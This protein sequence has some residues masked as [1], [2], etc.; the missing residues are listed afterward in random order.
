MCADEWDPVF[1]DDCVRFADTG[2][3]SADPTMGHKRG[4]VAWVEPNAT[5]ESTFPALNELL[6]S[7][8]A[9]AFE[10]NRKAPDLALARPCRGECTQYV[11]A[12]VCGR[13]LRTVETILVRTLS[14]GGYVV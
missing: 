4:K 9:L 10:L 1:L 7:L 3:L 2:Q 14:N 5:L 8:H 13:C 12:G 6:L 11:F